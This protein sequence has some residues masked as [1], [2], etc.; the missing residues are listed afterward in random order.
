M[1]MTPIKRKTRSQHKGEKFNVGGAWSLESESET[2]IE[3]QAS[4]D[5]SPHVSHQQTRP[6]S[7]LDQIRAELFEEKSAPTSEPEYWD[8][9]H[10]WDLDNESESEDYW[11]FVGRYE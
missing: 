7:D 9:S 6:G 5:S 2:Q 11:H 8:E 3:E 1:T 10:N 4:V